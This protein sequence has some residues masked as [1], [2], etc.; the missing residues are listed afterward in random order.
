MSIVASRLYRLLF[1]ALCNNV[2]QAN[3]NDPNNP[4]NIQPIQRSTQEDDTGG[5]PVI[6]AGRFGTLRLVADITPATSAVFLG[7]THITPFQDKL[8]MTARGGQSLNELWSWSESEG[9]QEVAKLVFSP[10]RQEWRPEMIVWN[11]KLYFGAEET[12]P[13]NV[14]WE[15][16]GVSNPTVVAD[17]IGG[18]IAGK[19]VYRDKLM[20]SARGYVW[21]FQPNEAN[22]AVLEATINGAD[23]LTV[24]NDKM[25]FAG[26]SGGF[27][28][29]F[30]KLW[31]YN[32]TSF[33]VF[34]ETSSVQNL[35]VYNDKLYFEGSDT[36]DCCNSFLF[37]LDASTGTIDTVA[38]LDTPL[39]FP[40]SLILP[41][42]GPDDKLYLWSNDPVTGIE[43][44]V[45]DG[46]SFSLLA[47]VSP[48]GDSLPSS[49]VAFDNKVFFRA[50]DGTNG[51]E[52]WA[53]DGTTTELVA[54]INPSG[55]SNP[56]YL[57]VFNGKLYFQADDG[58]YGPELWEL[59]PLPTDPP[60]ETPTGAPTTNMPTVATQTPTKAPITAIP[61]SQRPTRQPQ[62]LEPSICSFQNVWGIGDDFVCL[63]DQM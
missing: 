62:P 54:D 59:E 26:L 40:Y 57:T 12:N 38:K 35:I 27:G 37:S 10:F 43:P 1:L 47:D 19:V 63:A 61:I 51:V 56:S 33:E 22:E 41:G 58:E 21:S 44:W 49:F 55:D 6:D 24:Y 36:S 4:Q 48:T 23:F 29:P 15:Y 25:Y 9:A 28:N 32:G 46:T 31:V 60:T 50:N 17:N 11:D 13:N 53:F 45:Y 7:P 3:Q 18:Y 52:L 39:G 14:L 30:R 8:Y 16:D 42:N 34:D 20:F 2:G 5:L